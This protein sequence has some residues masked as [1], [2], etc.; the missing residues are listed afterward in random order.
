MVVETDER[1]ANLYE[2]KE[3][4]LTDLERPIGPESALYA[5]LLQ[6]PRPPPPAPPADEQGAGKH[7]LPQPLSPQ[8]K[9]RLAETFWQHIAQPVPQAYGAHNLPQAPGA[10]VEI[11]RG[12]AWVV[13]G[14]LTAAEC[15]DIIH[16]GEAFGIEA[17]RK[18][19]GTFQLRTNKRTGNYCAPELSALVA[20]RL[21]EQLLTAIEQSAPHTAVRALHPNWRIAK[22][23]AGEFFAAHY[24]QADSLTVRPDGEPNG[25]ARCDSTHTFLVSLS[26]RA[27]LDG[28]ATRLFPEGKYDDS[29][30]DVELPRGHA[31]VFRHRVL[32]AGLPPRAGVKYIAQVGMLR[33]QPEGVVRGGI[34]VFKPGPGLDFT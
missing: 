32:H 27:Q 20:P 12:Q 18:E 19:T 17:N 34:S 26:D 5:V 13:A 22:Y 30:I 6:P 2:R 4:L 33:G 29:A 25:K 21:P 31:L 3:V 23:E 8:S 9:E 16:A 14:V 10:V 1:R 7:K 24:D 11:V 28:G 15:D